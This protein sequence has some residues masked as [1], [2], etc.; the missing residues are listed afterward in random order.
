[1][2]TNMYE[3]IPCR[4]VGLV[5]VGTMGGAILERLID[6]GNQVYAYDP[7]PDAKELIHSAGGISCSSVSEISTLCKVIFLVLPGPVQVQQVVE[8]ILN[9]KTQ[10]GMVICDFT[11]STPQVTR[12][13]SQRC[14]QVGIDFLDTPILGRPSLAG[15]WCLPVGGSKEA[16]D[17]VTPLLQHF[18]GKIIRVGESGAGHTLK[19]LNQLM[20]NVTNAMVVEMFTVASK[21]GIDP[22]VIYDVISES[23][24]AT[25]SGLFKEVGRKIVTRDFEPLFSIDLL[26]KDAQLSLEMAKSW[27]LAPE[28]GN[29]SQQH[30]LK[31]RALGVGAEDTS[32][33][34]KIFE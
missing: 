31:A 13:I 8:E 1:M 2:E 33:L 5:G 30:N 11:T 9:I 25:V 24:A 29:L 27:G 18:A 12:L 16:L 21:S 23:G 28:L 34:V 32:A 3:Q 17:R 15:R 14:E 6:G 22:Q 19:L 20:F 4:Q 7:S 26:I 10:A